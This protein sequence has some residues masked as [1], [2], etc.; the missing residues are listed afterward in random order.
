M[1][2]APRVFCASATADVP[3]ARM[4]KPSA[5]TATGRRARSMDCGLIEVLLRLCCRLR[6]ELTGSGAR[7][8]PYGRGD[9]AYSPQRAQRPTVVPPLSRASGHEPIRRTNLR[10]AKYPLALS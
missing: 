5:P 1:V 7:D 4:A 9:A 10:S 6:G 3:A 2:I 8:A